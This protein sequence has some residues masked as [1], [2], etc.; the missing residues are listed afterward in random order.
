MPLLAARWYYGKK[1]IS[2]TPKK[3]EKQILP[4]D[5]KDDVLQVPLD[6]IICISSVQIYMEVY[7]THEDIKKKKLLRS[8]LKNVYAQIRSFIQSHHSHIFNPIHI[9]KWN[10]NSE[11]LVGAITFPVSKT[12][13][14]ILKRSIIRSQ[15]SDNQ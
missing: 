8:T 13:E 11:I 6:Q 2:E 4:G 15:I 3:A 10:S 14:K 12:S 9:V 1:G 7:Y 5:N